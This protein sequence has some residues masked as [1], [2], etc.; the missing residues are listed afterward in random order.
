M[1]KAKEKPIKKAKIKFLLTFGVEGDVGNV[2]FRIILILS[3]SIISV[4]FST[5][6]PKAPT[7]INVEKNAENAKIPPA[8][9][10]FVPSVAGLLI[11][12]EVIKDIISK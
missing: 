11:A 4:I 5:E 12:G 2:P 10:A 1:A 9:V 3:R 6:E 7:P 8:S